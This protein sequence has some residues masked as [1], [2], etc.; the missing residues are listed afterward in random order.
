MTENVANNVA[1]SNSQDLTEQWEKRKLP[2]GMYYIKYS[3][4]LATIGKMVG[5]KMLKKF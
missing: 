5:M 1:Q 4:G 3:G 2:E